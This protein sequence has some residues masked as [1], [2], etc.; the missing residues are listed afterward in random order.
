MPELDKR[1]L[2]TGIG[3]SV[4][5]ILSAIAGGYGG[6]EAGSLAAI[7]GKSITDIAVGATTNPQDEGSEKIGEIVTKDMSG[8]FSFSTNTGI[9]PPVGSEIKGKYGDRARV[10]S[11]G[12]AVPLTGEWQLGQGVYFKKE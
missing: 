9:V 11:N 10:V 4:S 3:Y 5:A 6:K 8:R 2:G 7:G 1:Q 12:Q